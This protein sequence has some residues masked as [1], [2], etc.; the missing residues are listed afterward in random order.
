MLQKLC[1]LDGNALGQVRRCVE[2]TPVP[3]C[4]H[5]SDQV[6]SFT[7][8]H[9]STLSQNRSVLVVLVLTP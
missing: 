7:A 1:C 5:L 4:D 2:L 3:F 8:A 6:Q 9:A